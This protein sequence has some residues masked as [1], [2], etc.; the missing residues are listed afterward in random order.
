MEV[1]VFIHDGMDYDDILLIA[2]HYTLCGTYPEGVS[3]DK[4]RA[5]RKR[6]A[7]LNAAK[8]C[9]SFYYTVCCQLVSKL[10]SLIFNTDG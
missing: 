4:K 9:T 2:V 7:T 6:A 8:C 3:K 1:L 5:A 10:L